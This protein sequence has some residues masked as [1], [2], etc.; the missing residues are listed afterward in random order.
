PPDSRLSLVR[1]GW[2]ENGK[3]AVSCHPKKRW[4]PTPGRPGAS[5]RGGRLD[6]C[7]ETRVPIIQRGSRSITGAVSGDQRIS[8][9][10][11]VGSLGREVWCG[12]VVGAGQARDRAV[13]GV[14]VAD[15]ADR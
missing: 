9:F 11:R 6:H 2:S 14:G 3:V 15:A 4:A 8:T 5:V 13:V 1:A 12:A 10:D 7:Q